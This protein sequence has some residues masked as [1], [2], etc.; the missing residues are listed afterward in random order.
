LGGGKH[1]LDSFDGFD[2]RC[3]LCGECATRAS[4]VANQRQNFERVEVADQVLAQ[5]LQPMTARLD[6]LFAVTLN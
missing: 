3:D 6:C 5:Y 1:S 2:V 4:S